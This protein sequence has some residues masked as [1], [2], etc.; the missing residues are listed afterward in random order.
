MYGTSAEII[1]YIR[2]YAIGYHVKGELWLTRA[3]KIRRDLKNKKIFY[4]GKAFEHRCF[5]QS[6]ED[7]F[8]SIQSEIVA[9]QNQQ[10][11]KK[12]FVDLSQFLE[13]GPFIDWPGLLAAG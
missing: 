11:F 10:E 6:S 12:R 4:R 1:G 13:I 8:N 3:K 5:Y 7:I 2:I 9:I